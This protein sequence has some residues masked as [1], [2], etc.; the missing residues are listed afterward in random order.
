MNKWW[1]DINFKVDQIKAWRIGERKICVQRKPSEWLVWD[2]HTSEEN[3]EPLVLEESSNEQSLSDVVPKRYL[4]N[5]TL[6]SLNVAPLLANRSVIVRPSSTLNVLPGEKVELFV[7]SP[8]WLAFYSHVNSSPISDIPFWQPSDSW[9]GP[10]TMVGELCYSKYTEAKVNLTNIQ[11]R[12]HRAITTISISNEHDEL[13][14]IDRISLPLPFLNLYVDSSEQFWTDKICLIHHLD[15][16]RPSFRIDKLM[17]N[18]AQSAL[19]LVSM[20]REKTDEHTFMRSI[21][22]LVA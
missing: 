15:G 16:D 7:S 5:K 22:S 11:K 14:V 4:L 21:K 18:N 12:S 2:Q 19:E 13:L 20:A 6:G 1:G 8:M 10:S 17:K 3:F 9:F